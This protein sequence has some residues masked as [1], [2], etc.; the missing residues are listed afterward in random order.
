MW[1]TFR[2]GA[3]LLTMLNV[4]LYVFF[5]TLKIYARKS[6]RYWQVV[7]TSGIW[8]ETFIRT[9]DLISSSVTTTCHLID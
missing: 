3:V 5:P 7:H 6:N 4:Y 9:T 1:Y 2:E 8:A